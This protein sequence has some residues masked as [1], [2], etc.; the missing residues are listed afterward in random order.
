[1]EKNPKHVVANCGRSIK[2]ILTPTPSASASH[3]E[4]SVRTYL[5]CT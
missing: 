4:S 1:M 3:R 2:I 5:D